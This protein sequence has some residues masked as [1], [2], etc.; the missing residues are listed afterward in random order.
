VGRSIREVGEG[1]YSTVGDRHEP[2]GSGLREA[3]RQMDYYVDY[4]REQAAKYQRRK[5][6]TAMLPGR[7]G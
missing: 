1:N 6:V 7:A 5:V 2:L 3:R 4:L